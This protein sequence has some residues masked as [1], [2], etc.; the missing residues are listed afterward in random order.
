LEHSSKQEP[1]I[2]A[3]WNY[4]RSEWKKFHRWKLSQGNIFRYL[5]HFI[6]PPSRRLAPEIKITT[7]A[8]LTND[9]TESFQEEG[10]TFQRV[11]IREAGK[12]NVMEIFYEVGN[13]THEIQIPIPRGKLKEAIQLQEELLYRHPHPAHAKWQ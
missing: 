9:R 6:L 8:V 3:H 1:M 4:S 5:Y 13:N 2:L 10:R 7:K 12:M 11:I